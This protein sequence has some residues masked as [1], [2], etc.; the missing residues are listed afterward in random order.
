M[1]IDQHQ[2]IHSYLRISLIERCNLRCSYCMP[3]EGIP[4][5]PKSHIMRDEE[6]IAIATEYVNL[7]VKK[8]RL[9]G[10]EPLM[11]KG[12]DHI[13]EGLQ[14]LKVD[15]G[16]TTNAVLLDQ[17]WDLLERTGCTAL[18]ISLDSLVAEKMNTLS[19]RNKFDVIMKNI[20]ETIKRGFQVKINVVLL[21]GTNEDEIIDFIEW[22]RHLPITVRFI[23][24][25][26]FNGNKWD[27]KEN[28]ISLKDI[29]EKANTHFG[30]ENVERVSDAPNDVSKNYRI[31]GSIGKFA[32]ISTVSNPFCDTCNRIRLT[33][34]GKMK[35]CL[36]SKSETDI[37]SAYRKGEDLKT[38]ITDGIW[39]KKAVRAGMDSFEDFADPEQNQDNRS[40]IRI[41]G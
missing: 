11:R 23:E 34:D 29:L 39:H 32:V 14:A 13:L 25:M 38:V 8:I 4:L 19:R 18:N 22:G 9:T 31:K 24:F 26:P 16:M 15:L 2:R 35:N 17:H 37:L 7:G 40:M 21:K 30:S 12:L 5:L 33:A 41:G 1:I 3:E 6:V 27:W 36:F 10:G 28:G 20:L